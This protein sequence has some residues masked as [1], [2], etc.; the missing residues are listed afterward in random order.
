MIFNLNFNAWAGPDS[1]KM[2]LIEYSI[3]IMMPKR[4]KIE[5]DV[6]SVMKNSEKLF[7]IISIEGN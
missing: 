6:Y 4:N 3:K 2:Y 7:G 5:Q 1:L